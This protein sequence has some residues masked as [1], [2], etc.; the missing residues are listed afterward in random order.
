MTPLQDQSKVIWIWQHRY[1]EDSGFTFP[2][3]FIGTRALLWGMLVDPLGEDDMT[4][5]VVRWDKL[6]GS[7]DGWSLDQLLL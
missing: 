6:I 1:T 5:V 2:M 4:K 7:T 3:S